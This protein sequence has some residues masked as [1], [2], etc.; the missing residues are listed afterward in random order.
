VVLQ[1]KIAI[2][3]MAKATKRCLKDLSFKLI[4][5][6]FNQKLPFLMIY[7]RYADFASICKSR[8]P[9]YLQFF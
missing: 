6:L 9:D 2:A 4:T 3:P 1:S 5:L 7:V 8:I